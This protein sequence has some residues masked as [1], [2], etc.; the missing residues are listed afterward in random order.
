[1][2]YRAALV[3]LPPGPQYHFEAIQRF[4]LRAACGAPQAPMSEVPPVID[5]AGAARK[6]KQ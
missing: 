2:N 4:I 1:M 5:G 3:W 6:D